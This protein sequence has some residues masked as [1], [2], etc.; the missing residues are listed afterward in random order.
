MKSLLVPVDFSDVTVRVIAAVEQLARAFGAKVWLLHCV[1]EKPVGSIVESVM[2]PDPEVPLSERF[3]KEYRRLME[4]VASMLKKGGDVEPIFLSGS[5]VDM[6]L[7]AA[8]EHLVDLI[9]M[10]SHGHGALYELMVG[11]VTQSILHRGSRPTLIIPS[12]SQQGNRR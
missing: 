10:G 6:I 11:T 9:V 4:L 7:A 8:D 2:P 5:A 1:T 12:N 3:P